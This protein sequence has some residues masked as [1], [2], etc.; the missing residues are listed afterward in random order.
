MKQLLWVLWV[1]FALLLQFSGI[2]AASSNDLLEDVFEEPQD[3][4]YTSDADESDLFNTQVWIWIDL[5]RNWNAAWWFLNI[6]LNGSVIARA[7]QLLLRLTVILWIPMLLYSGIRI[8]LSLWDEAK[9]NESLKHVWMIA[10]GLF[11]ALMSVAVVYLII[12]ITRS[13]LWNI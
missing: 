10:L 2:A 7:A 4:G 12:S 3:Y 13:N 8:M 5:G 11:I 6:W 1:I 9:L